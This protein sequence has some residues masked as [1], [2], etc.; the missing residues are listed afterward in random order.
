MIIHYPDS[1]DTEKYK[2]YVDTPYNIVFSGYTEGSLNYWIRLLND[3][4]ICLSASRLIYKLNDLTSLKIKNY[5]EYPNS[6]LI[7][8]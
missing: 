7:I 1:K 5:K 6:V 3:T 2:S 8:K 4:F